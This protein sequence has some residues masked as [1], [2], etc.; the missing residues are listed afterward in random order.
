[1]HGKKNA[2]LSQAAF[3]PL[4][5]IFRDSHT[6]QGA[7]DPGHCSTHTRAGEWAFDV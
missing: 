4:G 1:M 6:D 7:R 5:L 2:S 3:V